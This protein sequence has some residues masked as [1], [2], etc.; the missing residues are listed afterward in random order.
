MRETLA[1][2]M[3]VTFLAIEARSD[4]PSKPKGADRPKGLRVELL[5]DAPSEDSDLA[6]EGMPIPLG[7]NVRIP[8]LCYGDTDIAQASIRYRVLQ[9]GAPKPKGAPWITVRLSEV[10]A[11]EKTGPFN[12]KTGVFKNS[13]FSEPVPF[14]A[15]AS[16]AQTKEGRVL[17]GGR[18]FLH[19]GGLS[20][21]KGNLVRLRTGDRIEYCIDVVEVER[22]GAPVRTVRSP[23]RVTE[24]VTLQEF[25][26]WLNRRMEE[27]RRLH[28]LQRKQKELFPPKK[29]VP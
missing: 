27:Q 21:D 12:P 14:H 28:D 13:K 1:L 10:K 24:V 11:D 2:L 15:I 5:P 16:D 18:A 22:K 8:Y 29:S 23:V 6:F 3:V 19:T 4:G 20:D 26:E 9:N 25:Q 7:G 17:A